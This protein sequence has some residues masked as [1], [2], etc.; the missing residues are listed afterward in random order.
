[1]TNKEY[2]IKKG[3]QALSSIVL[4]LVGC[5]FIDDM[6]TAIGCLFIAWAYHQASTKIE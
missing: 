3:V 6:D 2:W 4:Y 5:F 1:M